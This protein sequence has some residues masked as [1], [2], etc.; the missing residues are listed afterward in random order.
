M[1]VTTR[2]TTFFFSLLTIG[3][4]CDSFYR[5]DKTDTIITVHAAAFVSTVKT[6]TTTTTTDQC[7]KKQPSYFHPSTF[8]RHRAATSNSDNDTND[9]TVTYYSPNKVWKSVDD[10]EEDQEAE[11]DKGKADA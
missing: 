10:V 11:H 7:P 9:D 3:Y 5:Y 2:R 6:I 4:L 1:N 8:T